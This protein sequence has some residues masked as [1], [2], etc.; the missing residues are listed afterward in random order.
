MMNLRDNPN[1]VNFFHAVESFCSLLDPTSNASQ[2]KERWVEQIQV[3]LAQLYAAALILPN[4]KVETFGLEP[5][6]DFD[7]S[8][9]NWR[10]EFDFAQDMLAGNR[11]YWLCFNPSEPP[12]KE[13]PVVGDLADDLAGIHRDIMPALRAWKAGIDE[14]IPIILF[15]VKQTNFRHWG[16]HAVHALSALHDFPTGLFGLTPDH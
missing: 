4:P 2:D 14:W 15:D 1:T 7:I 6:K 9:D 13:P 5:N 3:T 8:Q 16:H 11:F 12:D 10:H